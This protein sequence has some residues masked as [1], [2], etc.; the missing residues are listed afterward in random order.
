MFGRFLV[1]KVFFLNLDNGWTQVKNII[2]MKSLQQIFWGKIT[3]L[4]TKKIKIEIK[5]LYN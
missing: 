5:K 1:L 2:Y 3:F 4:Q